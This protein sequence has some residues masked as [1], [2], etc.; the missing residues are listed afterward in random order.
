MAESDFDPSD[1]DGTDD[2][3]RRYRL[4]KYTMRMVIGAAFTILLFMILYFVVRHMGERHQSQFS[5]VCDAM[6][7]ESAKKSCK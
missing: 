7:E 2:W 5:I 6:R 1:F 3:E 4:W